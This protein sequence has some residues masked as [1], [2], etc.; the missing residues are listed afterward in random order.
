MSG[1]YLGQGVMRRF[2]TPEVRERKAACVLSG[3]MEEK[4]ELTDRLNPPFL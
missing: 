1:Q 4:W 2:A 3:L